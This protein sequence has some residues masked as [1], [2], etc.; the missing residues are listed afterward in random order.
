MI[1]IGTGLVV[2][3]TD[4]SSET[5]VT[6]I[7]DL[8]RI[9]AHYGPDWRQALTDGRLDQ[10]E[11]A[12]YMAWLAVRRGPYRPAVDYDAFLDVVA[13]ITPVP[14]GDRL[15]DPTDAARGNGSPSRLPSPPA[16]TRP[17]GSTPTPVG[18]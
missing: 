6:T 4:G 18:S 1:G 16:P 10:I 13:E 12:V 17:S 15:P 14:G 9:G 7:G 3:Y 2:A 5:V 11:L 8:S